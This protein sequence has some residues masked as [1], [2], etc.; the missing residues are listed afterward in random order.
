MFSTPEARGLCRRGTPSGVFSLRFPN[1]CFNIHVEYLNNSKPHEGLEV[2]TVRSEANGILTADLGYLPRTCL[3]LHITLRRRFAYAKYESQ[4]MKP[5]A[6]E[7]PITAVQEVEIKR[8][9]TFA[10]PTCP[11]LSVDFLD[12]L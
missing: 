5:G 2:R 3:R 12:H 11:S 6:R 10:Q 4:S 1:P 7:A 8:I 9:W